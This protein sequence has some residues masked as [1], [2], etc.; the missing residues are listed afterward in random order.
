MSLK[1]KILIGIGIYLLIC[2]LGCSIIYTIRMKPINEYYLEKFCDS[3]VLKEKYGEIN[4]VKMNF[5]KSFIP[6]TYD[7]DKYIEDYIIY[8]SDGGKHNLQLVYYIGETDFFAYLID[9]KLVYEKKHYT[10]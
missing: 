10:K 6:T 1:K 2:G 8:T 4:K 7:E 5:I 3:E 9:G